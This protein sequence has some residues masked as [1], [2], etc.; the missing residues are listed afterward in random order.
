MYFPS[1]KSDDLTSVMLS[2]H[3]ICDMHME[4]D[5]ILMSFTM[6][7]FYNELILE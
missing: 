3:C 1:V 5:V 4:C 6:I 7:E 2:L